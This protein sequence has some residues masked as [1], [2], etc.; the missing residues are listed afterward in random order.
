MP[1]IEV[2]ECP[3]YDDGY[4]IHTYDGL[5]GFD[6]FSS[7]WK[8]MI[9]GDMQIIQYDHINDICLSRSYNYTPYMET[10][11]FLQARPHLSYNEKF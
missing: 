1:L 7:T 4:A 6:S 5:W 9:D 3:V 8:P 11:E 10:W 2:T